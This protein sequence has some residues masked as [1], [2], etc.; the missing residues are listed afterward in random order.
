MPSAPAGSERFPRAGIPGDAQ[1]ESLRLPPHSVEAEQAVLGGLLLSNTAWDRIGDV[2]GESDFYRADHR[3]IWRIISRLIED[4]KPADVLTVVEALKTSG[5]TQ[6]AGG[7]A[8]LHQLASGT[9][10]AANIRRYAEIVRERAI[11]RKLAEVGT[12]I[13]DSAYSPQGREARQLLDEAETRILEIGE[14]NGRSS[15]VFAEM[16]KVL[17]EVMSRLDELHRNPAAVTGK[18][19]GYTDLDEMTTGLQ[20]GD[21]I[22]VA[23][24]PSMGKAQSIDALVKTPTGWASMGSLEVGDALASVD[25]AASIVTGVFPQGERQVYRITFSDGRSTEC[26]DEHLWRVYRSDWP[27]SRLLET[28]TLR[29]LVGRRAHGQRIWIDS[30]NGEFGH[31][32]RLPID[33][34]VLGSLIASGNGPRT[35]EPREEVED[36][37]GAKVAVR[38]LPRAANPLAETLRKLGLDFSHDSQRLIP[39]PYM[40]A[41]RRSRVALLRGLLDHNAVMEDSGAVRFVARGYRL[42]NDVVDL[43]R[44]LG[45]WC[46][47]EDQR[48]KEGGFVLEIRHADPSLLVPGSGSRASEA[49]DARAYIVSIQPSRTTATQ[50]ISVSHPLHLYITDDYVV[51]HNTSFALNIAE[52]VG[53]E[54]KLPVLIFSME[55]GGTQLATRLLGSV[56]KV[57]AQKLR[58]GRLDTG[59]WDRL[60]TALG[61]LNEAPILIDETAALNPLELR[62]RARRKWR[63]YGALGLIVIDYI[64]LMQGSESGQQENRATEL[65]EISRGLKSMAKE[66]GCPVMA[67]SQLNRSLEQRPNKRPVMSDLRECVTGETLVNLADGRRV[68]IRELVGTTPEVLAVTEEGK[69]TKAVSDC[70]WSVGVKPVFKV[71]LASG[72]T[73]RATAKHRL[74][75]GN[76]W[77]EVGNLIPGARIALARQLPE[78]ESNTRW[79]D[80]EL[81]LL[82]QLVGDGSYLVHAPLRY[83]TASEANS[84]AVRAAAES[85][86]STVKR[87][88]GRGLWHQLLIGGNGNRW[89]AAG[90]GKWLKELGIFG[91]RSHEKRLPERVFQLANDQIALLLRHLW[92]TDGSIVVRPREKRGSDRVYYC[93]TSRGLALDV[94]A[95][96]QRLGI[97]ARIRT[98]F[99]A[100]Y[101]AAYHVDVSGSAYQRTFLARVG[102]FGERVAAAES[103][104][105]KLEGR[106]ENTNVD[107]L[108]L[109]AFVDVRASMA[110]RNMSIRK[111]ANLRGVAPQAAANIYFAPSR[112]LIEDYADKLQDESLLRWSRSDLFWDRVVAIEPDGEEEV[113]D[114]TVPGPSCW[115]AD[116]LVSHNSGAL[117]QDSDMIF[118]IYRDEVYNEDS[119]DKGIAEI[120]IGKQRNGPIGTVKLT[121]LGKHTRFENY[122]GGGGGYGP[123]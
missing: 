74:L 116:G 100:G 67:L 73:I 84:E 35:Q 101:R 66:L 37:F 118:F 41:C 88:A 25:G 60:G 33:P 91:Q 34:W 106:V 78:P 76:N 99:K 92:A 46:R 53:L 89:H 61:K 5:E 97:V 69:I 8:Y 103:L 113:F 121:F 52:H 30:I 64:Q 114:L 42:A 79:A 105:A 49:A 11:M 16:S 2:V 20:D 90:V 22:I 51:T 83:T 31:T 63:E 104:R 45:G 107:T 75:C 70:V 17:A 50:C 32:E 7:L 95:L 56:G 119:P 24:R 44:S 81:I 19:T 58:T 23:G 38:T 6:D 13:A 62:A 117:E 110:Q 29:N 43:V 55:M 28:R 1:I 109:Q 57:D 47:I 108:P 18:A 39:E 15:E 112:A 65:G 4:N 87:Y 82:G 94:A 86:G 93:S 77:I 120:I 122:T 71:S 59:D 96:L 72:R 40:N 115:L 102:A 3:L 48:P 14:S 98:V 54:L 27:H 9:P 68:P 10:S 36:G 80:H 85:M 26:C 12:S 111:I 21:L 123:G